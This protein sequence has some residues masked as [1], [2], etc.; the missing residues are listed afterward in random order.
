V[1]PAADL[2]VLLK[3]LAAQLGLD[4]KKVEIFPKQTELKNGGR[5]NCI[6][7]PYVGTT[8]ND[9]M[10]GQ[11]GLKKTGAELTLGE[12]LNAAEALRVMPVKLAELKAQAARKK[13]KSKGN[14][15]D[16]AHDGAARAKRQLEKYAEHI[17][18]KEDSTGRNGYFNKAA[19]VMGRHVGAGLIDEE[20]VKTALRDAA[21]ANGMDMV[22]VDDMLQ[23]SFEK[24][25]NNPCTP[26][27]F[28]PAEYLAQSGNTYW[29]KSTGERVKLANFSAKVVEDIVLDD[30]S[31]EAQRIFKIE[32]SLGP[33][34]V[35]AHT[36]ESLRW[37]TDKFGADACV[38]PGH[39]TGQRFLDAIKKLGADERVRR[40]VFA[41]TG[42]RK[43][44]DTWQYLHAGCEGETEV[45]LDGALAHFALPATTD[46]KTAM[47]ASLRVLGLAPQHIAYPLFGAIYRAALGEWV[48]ATAALYLHG[49][50]G[51][52][53]TAAAMIGQAHFAPLLDAPAANW[54]ATANAL[55]RTAFLA[56]DVVLLV[57]D[58]VHK[59]GA[60]AQDKARLYYA[61]ERLIRG[62]ANRGGRGRL[63]ADLRA[64]PEWYSRAML[65]IT[66][67]DLPVGHSLRARMMMVEVGG[68]DIDLE[69]LTEM[70]ERRGLLAGAV[71]GYVGWLADQDKAVFGRRQ[72]ELRAGAIAELKNAHGRTAE[73]V[74]VFQIGVEMALRFAVDAGALTGQE[75]DEH[76]AASWEV[77]LD[78]ARDQ[79]NL[80]QSQNPA[81]RFINLIGSAISSGRAHVADTSGGVPGGME[82]LGWQVVARD[83]QA[84]EVWRGM[85]RCVG[86]AK[87]EL[88]YLDPDAAYAEAQ[89]LASAQ[90]ATLAVSKD[91]LWKRL[92]EAGKIAAKDQ[93]KNTKRVRTVHGRKHTIC[94]RLAEVVDITEPDS[95]G[96]SIAAAARDDPDLPF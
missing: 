41:H 54:E 15:G 13:S 9:K 36:F 49:K 85:G 10:R 84:N 26:E 67:E 38:T 88:I 12:F 23:R 17:A 20:L 78:L 5:G 91:T 79:A 53:K 22:K 42:W 35:P 90:H 44:N 93:G 16:D 18:A 70:Q 47:R 57:D 73:N 80:L 52:R 4:L 30:G 2:Q 71:A 65:V 45:K 39:G 61:A 64:R 51:A 31:G 87:D 77:L 76:S 28:A 48:P 43:I 37:V 83:G 66:G 68:G 24:G 25:R 14:G 32:S 29:I 86:W 6:T 46:V 94:L 7:A 8:F 69:V 58:F 63:T 21:E 59:D 89:G 34:Q 60:S 95:D 3:G 62:N 40:R 50:T 72:S 33:A 96:A 75:A 56:K 11:A 55:E 82:A 92:A 19:Y 81:E 27:E 1:E 74:A